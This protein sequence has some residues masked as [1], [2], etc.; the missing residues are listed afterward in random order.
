MLTNNTLHSKY[1]SQD[2]TQCSTLPSILQNSKKLHKKVTFFQDSPNEFANFET[3][4]DTYT[5]PKPIKVKSLLSFKQFHS[6]DKINLDLLSKNSSNALKPRRFI[7]HYPIHVQNSSKQNSS[8][9]LTATEATGN[10]VIQLKD[11]LNPAE[12]LNIGSEPNSPKNLLESPNIETDNF[13][14]P[15]I[16]KPIEQQT[17]TTPFKKSKLAINKTVCNSCIPKKILFNKKRVIDMKKLV[18]RQY[19]VYLFKQKEVIDFIGAKITNIEA[20]S[21]K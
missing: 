6:S 5:T 17:F 13:I 14:F 2:L 15:V 10:K 20:T 3:K 8:K 4:Q 11:L 16:N 9:E 7:S 18:N 21:Y 1:K 12:K 19:S